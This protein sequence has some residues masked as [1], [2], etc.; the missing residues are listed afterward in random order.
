MTTNAYAG[1]RPVEKL[2]TVDAVCA[3]KPCSVAA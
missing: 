3:V 1:I 2:G